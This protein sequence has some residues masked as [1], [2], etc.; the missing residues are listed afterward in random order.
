M[1]ILIHILIALAS[2]G[3]ASFTFFKPTTK[4]LGVSYG[5]IVATVA[6]GTFL[7]ILNPSNLLHT[8]LSGLFY[9]TV[10]SIVTIATH[11]RVRHT[12]INPSSE[13]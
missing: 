5:F 4:R 12:V 10:V 7:L 11:Y 6:S 2:L 8:C 1:I 3:I 13:N 9:L